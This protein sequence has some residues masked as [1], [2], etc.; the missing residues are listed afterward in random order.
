MSLDQNFY[1]YL[2]RKKNNFTLARFQNLWAWF[3]SQALKRN[4]SNEQFIIFF[5]TLLIFL[6]EVMEKRFS[7]FETVDPKPKE[8]R[9]PFTKFEKM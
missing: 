9:F 5:L 2:H 1:F 8:I 4:Y 6:F 3:E 7:F